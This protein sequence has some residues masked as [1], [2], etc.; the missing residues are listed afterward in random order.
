MVGG[1]ITVRV[2]LNQQAF[3][4]M[5][6]SGGMIDRA[7]GRAAGV[8]RDR[9]KENLTAAGRIDTGALRNSGETQRI[10]GKTGVWWEVAFRKSYA[11]YQHRGVKGPVL[12][13]R[14]KVLRFKPKG[15]GAF[16]FTRSTKGF[17]GVPYLT[18]ALKR[19]RASDFT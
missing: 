3:R 17:K 19:L 13:R 8:T 7:V 18:D 16:V 12:P 1:P 11:L 10:Q 5:E 9:A 15:G 14:A 6:N 2:T 4:R